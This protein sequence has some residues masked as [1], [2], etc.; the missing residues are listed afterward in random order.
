MLRTAFVL[1]VVLAACGAARA[2]TVAPQPSD[3]A[4]AM[5]GGWELSNADRDKTCTINFKLGPAATS[6][7]VELDKKC[8]EAFPAT[9]PVVAW[10]FGKNDMLLLIDNTGKPV[11]E[12]L[13]V[14]GGMYEGLR[15]N[16]GRYFLQNAAVAAAS[17]DKPADDLFGNW[18]FVR[19]GGRP[20]CA[21]TLANVAADADSFAIEIKP[22]CDQLIT[23]FGPRSWKMD[24]GQL[25]VLS[26]KGEIWRFEESD[27]TTWKRIPEAR[28]P[29]A[30]VKQ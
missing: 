8:G 14:E 23:R 28:Q 10:T 30:L 20:I 3:A 27:P 29:L 25:L 18:S 5:V 21:L 16:E 7:P 11:L 4:K 2:Q 24:R 13:E 6:Y 15:P 17:R 22:G 26:A 12:M 9:R 1:V 19:G